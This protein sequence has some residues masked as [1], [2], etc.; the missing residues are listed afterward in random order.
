MICTWSG[1]E[2]ARF[3]KDNP[4]GAAG[5]WSG[6]DVDVRVAVAGGGGCTTVKVTC[7][8]EELL[9]QRATSVYVVVLPGETA[10]EP[11]VATPP[12]LGWIV[13]LSALVTPPQLNVAEPPAVMVVGETENEA[14]FGKP[15]HPCGGGG[16]GMGVDVRVGMRVRVG[17]GA[18][19]VIV[20]LCEVRLSLP[21][22]NAS[23][24]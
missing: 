21:P 23:R 1:V 7:R 20:V 17:D 18:T 4:L 3:F 15:V 12:M 6:I 9:P 11:G 24:R 16:G 2:H 22:Q 19:T 13:T 10:V 8:V 5:G 14:M